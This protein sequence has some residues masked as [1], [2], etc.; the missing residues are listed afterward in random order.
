MKRIVCCMKSKDSFKRMVNQIQ[1]DNIEW[2]EFINDIDIIQGKIA[3]TDYDLVVIDEKLWWKDDAI[4]LFKKRNIDMII[5][6][7]DF[8]EIV[9]QIK[10]IFPMQA[11]PQELNESVLESSTDPLIVD[12]RE[13]KYVELEKKIFIEKEVKVPVYKSVYTGISNKLFVILGLSDGAGATFL[14]LNLAKYISNFNVLST[15]IEP[16][17]YNPCIYNLLELGVKFDNNKMEAEKEFYSHAHVINENK[18]LERD[19]EFIDDGI[20]WLVPDANKPAIENWDYYKM[21]KLLYSSKKSSI[22]F[23]DAGNNMENDS[24]RQIMDEA[25]LIFVVIEPSL[26]SLKNNVS[27]MNEYLDMKYKYKMPIEF[28]VNKWDEGINKNIFLDYMKV[29]PFAYIPFIE[30]KFIYKASYE[31]CIPLSYEEVK[32]KLNK[33]L[34]HISKLL[35]P[36]SFMNNN[37]TNNNDVKVNK[38]GGFLKPFKLFFSILTEVLYDIGWFIWQLIKYII[39]HPILLVVLI[40]IIL[41]LIGKINPV[42]LL[43]NFLNS[44]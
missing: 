14:T 20:V 22:S 39:T 9:N 11:P 1:Q 2:E 30:Q 4:E 42:T 34:Y 33:P 44:I 23:I 19:R 18:T 36:P 16:P 6:Q 21:M 27:K 7:G 5:F 32:D 43:L 8:E 15:I 10:V 12:D 38:K 3:Y 40:F 41:I 29:E 35:I 31:R 17:I 28:I 25:D 13:I 24:I 37:N 26:I